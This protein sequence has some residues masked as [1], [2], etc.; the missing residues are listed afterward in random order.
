LN[1]QRRAQAVQPRHDQI[2]HGQV[3]LKLPGEGDRLVAIGGF[4]DYVQAFSLEQGVQALADDRVVIGEQY[5]RA[6]R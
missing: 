2:D 6:H 4:A 1:L 3:R 5:G